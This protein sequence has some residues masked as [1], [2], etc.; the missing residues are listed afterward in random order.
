MNRKKIPSPRPSLPVDDAENMAE[1]YLYDSDGKKK[2]RNIEY[3]FLTGYLELSP[4]SLFSFSTLGKS[5][6]YP[7]N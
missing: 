4:K 5:L 3:L 7:N 6:S 1:V 2:N